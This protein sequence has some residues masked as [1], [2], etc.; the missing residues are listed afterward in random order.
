M[1]F[2]IDASDLPRNPRRQ[3]RL[4]HRSGRSRT[5]GVD[6]AHLSGAPVKFAVGPGFRKSA[7]DASGAPSACP[8]AAVGSAGSRPSPASEPWPSTPRARRGARWTLLARSPPPRVGS[9]LPRPVATV[10]TWTNRGARPTR[11]S[12]INC[13]QF[14][15]CRPGLVIRSRSTQIGTPTNSPGALQNCTQQTSE[16]YLVRCRHGRVH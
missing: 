9:R 6:W 13:R 15:G 12:I 1:M 3:S 16:G 5:R 14:R 11:P 8:R 10:R 7:A 2:A 4:R